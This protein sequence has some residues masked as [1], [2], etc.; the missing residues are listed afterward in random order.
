M[1]Y[2]YIN[3]CMCM[4]KKTMYIHLNTLYIYNIYIYIYTHYFEYIHHKPDKY[5]SCRPTSPFGTA[6][7][8]CLKQLLAFLSHQ[9]EAAATVFEGWERRLSTFLSL[10]CGFSWGEAFVGEN[11]L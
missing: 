7:P 9:W 4:C 3:I 5:A 11:I 10:N 1:I 2:I 6:V 8:P